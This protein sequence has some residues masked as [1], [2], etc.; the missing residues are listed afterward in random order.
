M[1]TNDQRASIEARATH[2][3][4]D[5]TTPRYIDEMIN[6]TVSALNTALERPAAGMTLQHAANV[7]NRIS[8][9]RDVLSGRIKVESNTITLT[10]DDDARRK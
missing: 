1:N 10:V 9:A 2:E 8:V 5:D 4:T 6:A 7:G 3:R